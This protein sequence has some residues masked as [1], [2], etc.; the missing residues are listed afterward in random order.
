MSEISQISH[1][2][3]GNT[4][5]LPRESKDPRSRRWFITVNNWTEEEYSQITQLVSTKG[6]LFVLG[7]EVGEEGTP[8]L[9]LYF[10]S[11]GGVAFST[12]KK[13]I[14]RGNF[15]ACKGN[16]QSNW[17]YITKD[18]DYV[19][20]IEMRTFAE[21]LKD[22]C[23]DE[24]KNVVW[25]EWQQEILDLLKNKATNS[26]DINWYWEET[27]N[28]G[29]SYLCKYL[30]LTRNVIICDGKKDNIF[31]QVRN[32][33]VLEKKK[34]DIILLDVPRSGVGFVNY[35]VIEQLKT[36]L[37]YSGKYEGG[38]LSFPWPHVIVFSN[39][40]PD[41]AAVSADRWVI[42]KIE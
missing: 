2:G 20:N 3:E 40:L 12:L 1:E 26:R 21:I 31:N 29:K 19:T 15:K 10:E 8:H 7:K 39:T 22:E 16:R 4:C 6:W 17:N 33:I 34:P 24:Y 9:H 14:P 32:T 37:I 38:Q 36:G 35:G 11:K 13:K 27:G 25:K 41:M 28:V 18:G 5:P 30:A 42:K 23:M